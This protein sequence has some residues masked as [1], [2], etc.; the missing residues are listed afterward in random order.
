MTYT[1]GYIAFGLLFVAGT[2]WYFVQAMK[3]KV[4]V[5]VPATT[6]TATDKPT[7]PGA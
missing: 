1:T 7:T 3:I 2:V 5:E 4:P 6:S